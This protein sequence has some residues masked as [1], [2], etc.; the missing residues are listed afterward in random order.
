MA[1]T[2]S[3][4]SVVL[5]LAIRAGMDPR[6]INTTMLSGAVRGFAV[7]NIY[8]CFQALQA[9]SQVFRFDGTNFDGRF[10][11]VPRGRN[12]VATIT[13]DDLLEDDED[14][15]QEKR[16]DSITIPR[17]MN[18]N[19]WDIAGGMATDKQTSE[20]A[21]DRRAT[22][23][24]QL[25][26]TVVL[27]SSEA[28]QAVEIN[29][30]VFIED[31]RGELKFRLPDN[32]LR[33]VP[34]D[35]VF[36]QHEGR[37]ERCRITRAD[38]F[39]GF[40]QYVLVRDRQTA[41]Q[42][43]AQ[44][45]PASPQALPASNVAGPTLIQA[46]DIPLLHDSEDGLGLSYYIAVAGA[47]EAWQGATVELSYDGGANYV[48][49]RDATV[50]IIMGVLTTA[51][52]DHPQATPD[53]FNTCRVSILTEGGELEETDLE[54]LLN[55]EN[56]A[57]IGDELV[58]FAGADEVSEGIWELSY[59]L[60]GRKDT[61][62]AAHAP[63][64]RFVMLDQLSAIPASVTDLGRTLTFRA[65][66]WGAAVDTGTVVSMTYT[67]KTQ[68]ERRP[69]YVMARREGDDAVVSWQGVGRLGAGA[70]V[71][72]GARF[73][74][75]RVTFDDGVLAPVVADTM[76]ETITQDVS[77]LGAPLTISVAQLNDLTGAGPATE[78][79]LE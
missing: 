13:E 38:V 79:I 73:A 66:T 26:T 18:L 41:Y 75:Y 32:F 58:Q 19:Y 14:I 56:L 9:L 45:Y 59:F 43:E 74:G 30:K 6:M 40:Q 54:G 62:T 48:D 17:V 44:G 2:Y 21:G 22:G 39:E 67:G 1:C 8:P 68:T 35:N 25:Q 20:R 24:M 7:V 50:P 55:G 34:S 63:G 31:Q 49:S 70:N 29:H 4:S 51:L 65:T 57:I 52:G 33:L 46:L 15:E 11:L 23:E 69:G 36:F 27:S 37:V 64:E 5:E 78:V 10:Q 47:S 28:A 60:R 3:L 53:E 16:G 71:A 77:A 72:H 42:S 76:A 12:A 61:E